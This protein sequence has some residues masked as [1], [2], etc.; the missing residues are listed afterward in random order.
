MTAMGS[1]AGTVTSADGT[2]IGFESLGSGDVVIVVGGALRAARDYLPFAEVL[3][4]SFTVHVMDR[5][6]RGL[7]GPQGA[8]YVMEKECEDLLALQRHTGATAVF[9]HSYGGLVCLEVARQSSAFANVAVYEPGVSVDGCIPSGW[10][11][12]YRAMLLQGDTRGAF[13]CMVQGAGFAPPILSRLPLWYVRMV[14][15]V[16]VPAREWAAMEPLLAANLA[17]HEQVAR[18]D[19]SVQR[20]STIASRVFL[21]GGSKSPPAITSRTLE[22]LH[23]VITRSTMEILPGLGHRAPDED[24]PVV[25][26]RIARWLAVR[27][28]EES[29]AAA[30]GGGKK[31]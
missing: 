7:S 13:A 5:R 20:Y 24:A 3:A 19:G 4:R 30:M 26:E 15:R 29:G 16:V 6:G 8:D 10:L 2:T 28:T 1:I 17:E 18:L 27:P 31:S 9:G 21:L 25:G 14:L 23:G 11:P 12:R 22:A